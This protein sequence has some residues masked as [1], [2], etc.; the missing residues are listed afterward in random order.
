MKLYRQYTYTVT[1]SVLTNPSDRCLILLWQTAPCFQG[2]RIGPAKWPAVGGFDLAG[3]CCIHWSTT[4][5]CWAPGSTSR[6]GRLQTVSWMAPPTTAPRKVARRSAAAQLLS[7]ISP[8]KIQQTKIKL[9]EICNLNSKVVS[10]VQMKSHW[11]W[12]YPI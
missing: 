3:S 7:Q 8:L 4:H 6:H 12:L 2:F 5:P 9:T 10:I 11:M 1:C